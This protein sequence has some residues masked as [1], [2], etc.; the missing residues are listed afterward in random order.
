MRKARMFLVLG[1]WATILPYLGF[2]SA[3]KDTLFTLT[4]LGLI[5]LSYFL[6]K[7]YKKEEHQEKTFDNFRENSNFNENENKY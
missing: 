2:P 6:Y 3:W 7:D 1:I 5:G 4:G